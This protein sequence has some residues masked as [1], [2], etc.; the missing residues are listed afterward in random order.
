MIH[1]LLEGFLEGLKK[2]DKEG[3]TLKEFIDA[4]EKTIDIIK[5]SELKFEEEQK[6]KQ[7]PRY[8]PN[9]NKTKSFP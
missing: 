3:K 4:Y 8:N 6:I 1:E 2:A 7:Y 9:E 5:K